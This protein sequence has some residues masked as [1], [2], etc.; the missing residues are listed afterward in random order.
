MSYDDRMRDYDRREY[1]DRRDSYDDRRG[2]YGYEE[3]GGGYDRYDRDRR[4]DRYG[5]RDRYDSRDRYGDRDR[6]GGRDRGYGRSDYGGYRERRRSPPRRTAAVHQ[7]DPEKRDCRVY[8]WNLPWSTRWMD[9][10]DHFKSVGEVAYADV[11]TDRRSGRSKGCGIVEF[12]CREDAQKA[13]ETMY[14]TMIGDRKIALR[15]DKPPGEEGY[16]R[17]EKNDRFVRRDGEGDE[18]GGRPPARPADDNTEQKMDDDLNDYFSKRPSEEDAP[19]EDAPAEG[20][21]PAAEE[22]A[23]AAEEAAP[24]AEEAAPAEA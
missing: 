7:R 17:R 16:T 14:D 13:I 3:R 9:L 5:G 6:Y 4:D 12:T 11:M 22:A 19:A 10:K 20:A 8:V 23:P 18:R 2:G 24:A 21:A 1:D 15:E